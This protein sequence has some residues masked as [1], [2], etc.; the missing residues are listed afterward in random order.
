MVG[1]GERSND[2]A[3]VPREKRAAED[4]NVAD[5][6]QSDPGNGSVP[7]KSVVLFTS[8]RTRGACRCGGRSRGFLRPDDT[9]GCRKN[10]HGMNQP[11]KFFLL[12]IV[13]V[14]FIVKPHYRW[15]IP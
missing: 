4:V 7:R 14:F 12:H 15:H 3:A 6:R 9:A 2:R 13:S 11:T 5:N 10:E 1:W 8:P